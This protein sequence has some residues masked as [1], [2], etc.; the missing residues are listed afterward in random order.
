[1]WSSDDKYIENYV[2]NKL[3]LSAAIVVEPVPPSNVFLDS[4]FS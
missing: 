3:N 4:D 2:M 1:M